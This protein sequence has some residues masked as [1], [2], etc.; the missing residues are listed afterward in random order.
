MCNLEHEVTQTCDQW[1]DGQK[2]FAEAICNKNMAIEMLTGKG[3][4]S[5]P[6]VRVSRLHGADGNQA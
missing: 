5:L 1:H 6:D 4:K 2:E 3:R